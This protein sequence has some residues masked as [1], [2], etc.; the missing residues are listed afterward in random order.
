MPKVKECIDAALQLDNSLCEPYCSLGLYYASFE[1]NWNEARKNFLR[2]LELNPRYTQTH[3]WFGHYYLTWVEGKFD[4]GEKHINTAIELEPFSA[5][6]YS[7]KYAILITAGKAEEAFPFAMKGVEMDPDSMITNR[8]M[9]LAFLYNKQFAKATPYLE[10]ASKISNRSA[11]TQVDLIRLY[12]AQGDLVQ[13][14]AVMED[15]KNQIKEG[16]YVSSCIMSYALGFMGEI[17]NAM[18]YL[19][20]AYEEH[21]AYIYLLNH[22]PFVPEK[23]RQ[24]ERFQSFINKMAFP[25]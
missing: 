3:I 17:D 16:K 1:W 18:I 13:A 20:K 9:G 6:S 7:T 2:S 4:E 22:Y 25:E 21:D 23:L 10:Y 8:I 24:D 19:E 11:F 14:D 5:I 15:L 12:T